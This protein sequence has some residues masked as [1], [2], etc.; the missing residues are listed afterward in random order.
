MAKLAEASSGP[1]FGG[2]VGAT[3]IDTA[4]LPPSDTPFLGFANVLAF[5]LHAYD[6][7][8]REALATADVQG[9]YSAIRIR[10][11]LQAGCWR[12]E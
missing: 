7:G 2:P 6:L 8:G 3:G 10:S 11:G 12:L 4:Y 1:A 9:L 5:A